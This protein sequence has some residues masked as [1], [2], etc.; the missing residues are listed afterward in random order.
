MPVT[1][2]LGGQWGDEGKGQ[3]MDT[4][5][6]D[7]DIVARATGGSNAGHTVDQRAGRFAVHLIP[8]GIFTPGVTCVL[9]NGMVIGPQTLLNEMDALAAHGIDLSHLYISD[10]A[11]P[12]HALPSDARRV[13][14]GAARRG[15]DRHDAARH[16]PGVY[17]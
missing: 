4:L 2:V 13:R 5:A 16:R 1:I 3:I 6:K 11:P 14:G 7:A 8:S 12:R 9:G 10:K 15:G 17:G